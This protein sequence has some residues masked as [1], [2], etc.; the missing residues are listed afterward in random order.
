M[1]ISIRIETLNDSLNLVKEKLRNKVEIYLKFDKTFF[2][3]LNFDI[4]QYTTV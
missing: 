2:F 1:G 3:N 4:L